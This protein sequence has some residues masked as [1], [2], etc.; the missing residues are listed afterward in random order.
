MAGRGER[1]RYVRPVRAPRRPF[2]LGMVALPGTRPSEE[3]WK[4]AQ[5]LSVAIGAPDLGNVELYLEALS[6]APAQD[7][8][9]LARVG[10]VIL[11]APTVPVGLTHTYAN[12]RRG[13]TL[14]W[15]QQQQL[16]HDYGQ[17]SGA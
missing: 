14:D 13:R 16:E 15:D 5:R 11:M 17:A 12:S 6:A 10:A 8:G 1:A 4:L 9:R 2:D 3:S 7:L